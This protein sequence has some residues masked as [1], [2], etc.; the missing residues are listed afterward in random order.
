MSTLSIEKSR[1]LESPAPKKGSAKSHAPSRHKV[2]SAVA[3]ANKTPRSVE[4]KAEQQVGF[5]TRGMFGIQIRR[6]RYALAR[7]TSGSAPSDRYYGQQ[8]LQLVCE[9]RIAI[10]FFRQQVDQTAQKRNQFF[11]FSHNCLISCVRP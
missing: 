8:L 11:F 2:T 1:N 4:S 9:G 7:R 10:R 5:T 6:M 3:A